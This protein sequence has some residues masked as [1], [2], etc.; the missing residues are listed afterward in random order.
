M[1]ITNIEIEK[2]LKRLNKRACPG[3]DNISGNLLC[4]G[5]KELMPLFSLF[6]NK[7]FSHSKQPK[8][9]SLNF[10]ITIFKKGEIWDLDNYRG[11]AIGSTLG[12]IFALIILN[13][14][15]TL[16]KNT[17]PISPNQVGF[18]KGHRTSDHIFVLNTIV[19]RIVQVEKK[20]LFVAF[21]DFRKAYDK[22]NRNLMF[23]KL[24]R[25]GVK[26]LLYNNIKAIYDN[27]SY[28]I[29]VS[30][31]YLDP[32]PSTCGLK[33]GGVLS[34]LLFNLYIDEIKQI[35][36]DTCDPVKLFSA[37]LSHLVYADDLVLMSTSQM[38]LNKC[39]NQ[40]EK[41]CDTWQLEVNIKKSKV[42]IFN[43]AGRLV[44]GF[45]FFYRG[46]KLEIVKSYCYLG[47][48]F[49]CSG[50]FREARTNLSEK[51]Q[52][53]MF[54]LRAMI[55]QFQLP[56]GKSLEL[57]HSL[58][59]PIA[60]YN[61][62]NL[63][64]LTHHQI[65]SIVENKTTLLSYLTNSYLDNSQQK[66][67]KFILGV[68][69]NCSN[70]ATLG[71]LGEFP[72]LLNAFI[73]LLSFWHRSTQMQDDTLVKK[74]LQFISENDTSQ[75]EWI[76]TVKFLLNELNMANYL[77]NPKL[78]TT[79]KFTRIC[80]E[81]IRDKF[82]QLWF[83]DISGHNAVNG[84]GSKLRFYKL[85]KNAFS[86]EPYLDHINCFHLRKV[87]SKF[88]CS[89]HRLEIETGRH[90]KLKVEERICQLCKEN[91]ETE[92]HFLQECPLY[93]KLRTKYFGRAEITNGIHMLQCN[94][95]L[96]AFNVANYLTKAFDLRKRM[97]DLHA[98]FK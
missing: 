51:A 1:R 25:V 17:H 67:L 11:I 38:G 84:Q 8:L 35:F 53:A 46:K 44:N 49:M 57:F 68:K 91:I 24:Q 52:K 18:K 42:V 33:Q 60:L 10:L 87:V 15:E 27:I 55:K 72:L 37:P 94:D 63:A 13:R 75:S 65:K 43:P 66:F 47:I 79:E 62:E 41:F 82:I 32:I 86:R 29:K 98:Y 83:N 48:D 40:L 9:F 92:L 85:F 89:D 97:L 50:S 28:L 3:P 39:L 21:I 64:H 36:D 81:K 6:F 93:R 96:T 95:K 26:G 70:M 90:R 56:C 78:A 73:S 22:I 4:T 31:G 69:R 59:R 58:I 23:L 34:P 14:L 80:K 45:N 74:A 61:S 71:E 77:Q 16:I 2:A 19:K 76:A 88:R 7:L 54:P 12:K 30:G 5:E 20:K